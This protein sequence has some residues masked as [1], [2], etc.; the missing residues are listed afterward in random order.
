MNVPRGLEPV[1]PVHSRLLILGSF[2]GTMSLDR[3][4]YYAHPR[5]RFWSVVAAVI[6]VADPGAAQG[7]LEMLDR[8]GIALWDVVAAAERA[9]SLDAQIRNPVFNP[10]AT[11]VRSL[12]LLRAIA[13]N[14]RTAWKLGADLH[15]LPYRM[16]DLPSTS[17]ANAVWTVPALVER[18]ADI[19]PF[20][21][22]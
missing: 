4:S 21:V 6:G 8:A 18:W 11:L 9:G 22:A 1:A 14:G 17:P 10:V 5:N 2:P 13:F 16:I 19:R 3:R 15:Q 12:P 7:R 20:L